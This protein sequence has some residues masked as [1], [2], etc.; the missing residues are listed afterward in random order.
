MGGETLVG[1]GRF[2]ADG[3]G[4]VA[5]GLAI[6]HVHLGMIPRCTRAIEDDVARLQLRAVNRPA[7]S[8]H[9][10]R[11]TGLPV[12]SVDDIGAIAKDRP[13]APRNCG[14]AIRISGR[15]GRADPVVNT[16]PTSRR[17][18]SVVLAVAVVVKSLAASDQLLTLRAATRRRRRG[19]RGRAATGV[20]EDLTHT[21]QVR[22]GDAILAG[23]RLVRDA[24][25]RT[26]GGQSVAA[27]D[28]VGAGRGSN[29]G[30]RLGLDGLLGG[31]LDR[32]LGLLRLALGLGMLLLGLGLLALALGRTTTAFG[33]TTTLGRTTAALS[34]SHRHP[35]PPLTRESGAPGSG[36]STCP[37]GR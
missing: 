25:A 6:A 11:V 29:L 23:Q 20:V 31:L 37:G 9:G 24:Q 4:S 14:A 1:G 3:V 8:G 35:R 5:D 33:R 21:D 16:R 28:S 26:D 36:Q 30:R 18:F 7:V 22:V 15:A 10:A 32:L 2:V 12:L 19:S 13:V 34:F 17:I 27:L